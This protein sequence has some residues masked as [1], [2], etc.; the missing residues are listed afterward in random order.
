MVELAASTIRAKRKAFI[1]EG[2]RTVFIGVKLRSEV[3]VFDILK[4]RWRGRLIL[5]RVSK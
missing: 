3:F 4:D 2:R 5:W 1:G